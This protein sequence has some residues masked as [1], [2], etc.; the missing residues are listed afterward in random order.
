[1]WFFKKKNI[2]NETSS[3]EAALSYGGT[4][5]RVLLNNAHIA[6]LFHDGDQYGLVYTEKFSSSGLSPFN[7][8]DF[9]R[10]ANPEVNKVYNSHELW[11]VFS[12]RMPSPTRADYKRLLTSLGLLGD[13]DPLVILGRVGRVSISKPWKLELVEKPKA[14]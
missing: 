2:K 9:D 10:F 12:A 7:P 6:T 11:Q 13:E 8:N 5:L 3:D 4:V 14:S 1:M